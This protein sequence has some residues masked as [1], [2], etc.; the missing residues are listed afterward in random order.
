MK[1]FY[2]YLF[3]SPIPRTFLMISFI[4]MFSFLSGC[5]NIMHRFGYAPLKKPSYGNCRHASVLITNLLMNF[6]QQKYQSR[7]G[8]QC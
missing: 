7:N 8:H 6:N 1:E 3:E 5:E 4:S 2:K